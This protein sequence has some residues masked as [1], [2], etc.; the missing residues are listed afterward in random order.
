[1]LPTIPQPREIC[2]VIKVMVH[3]TCSPAAIASGR[4]SESVFFLIETA[5]GRND[6]HLH[7]IFIILRGWF[8]IIVVIPKMLSNATDGAEIPLDKHF[9]PG[10]HS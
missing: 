9:G 10:Q 8:Y 3:F 2:E 4:E 6:I 5:R 7:L 1:M